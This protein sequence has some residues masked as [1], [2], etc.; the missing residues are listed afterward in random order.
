MQ[1]FRLLPG[2]EVNVSSDAVSTDRGGNANGGFC[3]PLMLR[4]RHP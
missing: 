3:A 1:D 2:A 4:L